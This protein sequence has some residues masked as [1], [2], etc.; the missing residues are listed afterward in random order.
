MN[1]RGIESFQCS[2][3]SYSNSYGRRSIGATMPGHGEIQ[4]HGSST[5][6]LINSS[7]GSMHVF[8]S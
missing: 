3:N 6:V 8:W 5:V 4:I 1:I 2:A 7:Y